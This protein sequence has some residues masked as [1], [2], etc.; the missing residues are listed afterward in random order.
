LAFA[1]FFPSTF[2]ALNLEYANR[3]TADRLRQI[4]PFLTKLA[5]QATT[6]PPAPPAA[7]PTPAT[8]PTGK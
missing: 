4:E 3:M 2:V 5:T 6:P 8:V 7:E 1:F